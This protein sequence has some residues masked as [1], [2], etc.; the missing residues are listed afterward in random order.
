[1]SG[2]FRPGQCDCKIGRIIDEYDLETLDADLERRRRE[3]EA[4]LRDLAARTNRCILEAAIERESQSVFE[5]EDELF[6]AIDRDEAVAAIYAALADDET[7]PDRRARVRTRLEQVGIDVDGI[8]RDWVTHPTVRSHL[9]ECLDIDTSRDCRLDSDDALDTI[10]WARSRC[11]AIVGR[12][13]ER[14]QGGNSLSITDADVSVSIRVTCR[15]CNESYSPAR[16]LSR[17]GC[18]C[19]PEIATDDDSSGK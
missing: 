7:R 16:L 9:R 12:T 15:N 2:D 8:K 4:S 10:E 6:G 18:A 19:H 17:G 14:L 11:I 5:A 3:E 1:M 13:L